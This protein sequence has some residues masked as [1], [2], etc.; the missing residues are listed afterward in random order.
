M[1]TLIAV[2]NAHTRLGYQQCIRET[3]L[4]LVQGADVRFFLGPSE[5]I[6][7]EDEV[8]V[9]CDD[10]YEGLPSKV[11]AIV[12]WARDNGY[13]HICKLDDD[14]VIKPTQFLSTGFQNYDF[15]GHQNDK[16]LYPVP[17]GFCYWLSRR[18]MECVA[19]ADLPSDNN[20]EAW[21]T[22]TLSKAGIVLH[23][24][25]R[26]VMYVGKRSDFVPNK[27]RALRAPPRAQYVERPVDYNAAVALCMYLNWAGHRCIPDERVIEEMRKVFNEYVTSR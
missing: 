13:D 6:P 16:R 14:V 7:R 20:D 12:R 8:F 17:F 9:E 23:H 10:S 2:V 21:V 11:Q 22:D 18:S 1:K 27:P 3:W 4:P 19:T 25:P 26:Y 5:R 15:T 24:E